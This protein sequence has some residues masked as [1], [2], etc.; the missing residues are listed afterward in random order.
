MQLKQNTLLQGDKYRIEKVLG[1]GGFGITYLAYQDMLDRFV[2]IKEFFFKD[3]CERNSDTSH[4]T[5][6]NTTNHDFVDRFKNK[7]IK[8]A[9]T[10]SKFHHPNIISILDIFEENGTAYYV[11]DYIEGS[12]LSDIANKQGKIDELQAVE[13]IT[14]T[15]KALSYIHDKKINHL[16]IKPAN[17]MIRKSDNEPIII[18]FGLAKQYDAETGS[19]TSTTPVG[20]SHGYAPIEQYKSGGVSE[21]SPQTDIYSLGATF[22]KIVSGNTPPEP[23]EILMEGL[24]TLEKYIS[25][26]SWRTIEKS[27]KLSKK[28]RPQNIEEFLSL[29]LPDNPVD[30]SNNVEQ[31]NQEISIQ[32]DLQEKDIEATV[33]V[34]NTNNNNHPFV[35]LGLSVKWAK[36][37][38]GANNEYDMGNL[39]PFSMQND[40]L[41][42]NICGITSLDICRTNMGGDW[43]LPTNDEFAELRTKCIWTFD[44]NNN[45]Y[46]VTGPNGNRIFLPATNEQIGMGSSKQ[47][48]G[49][50]WTGELHIYNKSTAYHLFFNSFTGEKSWRNEDLNANFAVRAVIK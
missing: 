49:K 42:T 35:D 46:K 16:D 39:Y 15:A 7:F 3:F 47:F 5:L 14:K 33:I 13:Y 20:I 28:E 38:I 6:G 36:Y 25:T 4:V 2:C 50:Y 40:S 43:R 22:Y 44:H 45:G 18:D 8:E 32:D 19:Q 29:L 34:N 48:I 23:S 9:K 41:P 10:I 24:P 27:M 30:V 26:E 21:F 12:S 37:N 11:M 17:I 31:Y 1:Q